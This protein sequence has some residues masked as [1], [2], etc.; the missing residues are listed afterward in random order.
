M[1]RWNIKQ[2]AFYGIEGRRRTIN[3]T[4]NEVNVI[5][6]ASGTGKS[7]IID[8]IDYCLASTSCGLPWYVRR[9]A[10]AVAVHWTNDDLHLI[11]GR[12]IPKEGKGTAQMFVRTGKLLELPITVEGLEGRTPRETAKNIIERAF[13]LADTNDADA[14]LKSQTGRASIRH[15]TPYL[16]LSGDVIVSKNT[17]LHDLN[18]AEKARDIKA[19]M[20]YFLGAVDQKSVLAERQLRKLEA[21]LNRL[22]REAS[23][24]ARSQ[25]RLTKRSMGLLSQAAEVGLAEQPS[26][27]ASDQALLDLLRKVTI[28]EIHA[29]GTPS[30]GELGNLE[31]ERRS[32]IIG[33]ANMR[34]KRRTLKRAI[35]EASGYE[36][37]VSGQSH[38]LALI[39]HLNLEE[40]RC[41]V[42]DAETDL[43]Q[44]MAEQ[45]Q[46]SLEIVRDE[47]AAV[48]Q[49]QPELIELHAKLEDEINSGNTRLREIEV[50]IKALIRQTE[51]ASKAATLAQAR[52]LIIGRTSQFLETTVEDFE[53]PRVDFGALQG[54]IAELQD[55]IDP[56]AKRDRLRDAENM[57]SS[58][59]TDML[60]ELPTEVPATNARMIF[61][62]SPKV[63]L[64]EPERR[65]VLTLGEIGS[66]Q[67]YL[68]IHLA[69]A[70]AL[71][72][73]FETIAAPVPGFLVIDQ[74]SRPYYPEGGDEKE[75]TDMGADSDRTAMR[76]IINFLFDETAR[77]E[78]L[79]IL[80]IEHA[81]IHE[82]PRYVAATTARW[83]K[84]SGEKLIPDN[85]P[86][87]P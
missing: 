48:D 68:S 58:Y 62:S 31:T 72:K 67:N 14:A 75:L 18:R 15:V 54:E 7:A 80:L 47:V 53:I 73:H 60:V 36:T 52:A 16:F 81:Y 1:S 23:A 19:T 70:F 86:E 57:I 79:Q 74:I 66:D 39:E 21:A 30:G 34:E 26:A 24:N 27:D 64:I 5:T 17:L 32:L 71:Q 2:I 3:L 61:S 49:V 45:I 28:A 41:P 65:S 6:G 63:S 29:K 56:Q 10:V 87:R 51:T 8:A 50:Q 37:A 20:P 13:G 46:A 59:A 11:V 33:L 77:R 35:R 82:D 83:T 22:K 76:K 4:P 44:A 69:L 43:G 12:M 55:K 85:W 25:S 78:G 84:A 42:C 40:R 38:K 9:H